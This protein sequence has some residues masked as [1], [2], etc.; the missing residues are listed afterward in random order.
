MLTLPVVVEQPVAVA[1]MDFF[2]HFM[3]GSLLGVFKL[4]PPHSII[5]RCETNFNSCGDAVSI[6]DQPDRGKSSG[7]RDR[8]QRLSMVPPTLEKPVL[9]GG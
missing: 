6:L 2:R 4:R 8:D 3:N 7:Q 1:E 5:K 9:L